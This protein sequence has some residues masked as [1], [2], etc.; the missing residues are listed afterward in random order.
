[1]RPARRQAALGGSAAAFVRLLGGP[2]AARTSGQGN[3]PCKQN[4]F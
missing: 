2:A 1:M 3:R 4:S